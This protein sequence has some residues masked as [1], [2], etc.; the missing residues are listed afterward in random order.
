MQ[1]TQGDERYTP[2]E[3]RR[4]EPP[5]LTSTFSIALGTW[6][7]MVARLLLA[8][9]GSD[10]E[11]RFFDDLARARQLGA[12]LGEGLEVNAALS[13]MLVELPG[14]ATVPYVEVERSQWARMRAQLLVQAVAVAGSAAVATAVLGLSS[15]QLRRMLRQARRRM[16]YA[17]WRCGS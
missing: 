12:L 6:P 9:S 1:T 14:E 15:R 5:A 13:R 17:R 3:H 8:V 4:R 7:I 11:S 2:S 16:R 10:P